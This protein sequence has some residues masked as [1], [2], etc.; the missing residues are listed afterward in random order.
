MA[1][2]QDVNR[3]VGKRDLLHLAILLLLAMGIGTYL[4]ATTVLISSDGVFY[5][6]QARKFAGQPQEVLQGKPFGYP[7]LIFVAHHASELLFD[8]TSVLSWIYAAECLL[9][10]LCT[11]WAGFLSGRGRASWQF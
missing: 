6:E 2:S 1:V 7:F 4:I 11:F 3:P 5:I 9:W 8:G 10:R